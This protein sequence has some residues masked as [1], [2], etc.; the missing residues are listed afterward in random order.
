[1]QD[2]NDVIKRIGEIINISKN[3]LQDKSAEEI[4][5][6]FTYILHTYISNEFVGELKRLLELEEIAALL[7]KEEPF[8]LN[9]ELMHFIEKSNNPL[10]Y[11]LYDI[12][13]QSYN[14]RALDLKEY[15]GYFVREEHYANFLK[16]CSAYKIG[17]FSPLSSSKA[18]DVKEKVAIALNRRKAQEQRI[19]QYLTYQKEKEQQRL[20]FNDK[21][22]HIIFLGVN[23]KLTK[24]M[25]SLYKREMSNEEYEELLNELLKWQVITKMDLA[26]LRYITPVHAVDDLVEYFA[27]KE[28]VDMESLSLLIPSLGEVQYNYLIDELFK[29]NVIAFDDYLASFK[30][31][32]NSNQR[33]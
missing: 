24:D 2:L 6:N 3:N 12:L 5:S 14:S 31:L 16:F 22:A 26:E 4:K 18:E 30:N 25:I 33:R 11:P 7:Q 8:K 9:N 32:L 21:Y 23:G 17:P 29:L 20:L 13:K 27:K 1:M 10:Y 19:N 28:N 15:N